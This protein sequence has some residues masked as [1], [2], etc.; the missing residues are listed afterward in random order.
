MPADTTEIVV[1]H[2]A[3]LQPS[4]I[5]HAPVTAF[6]EFLIVWLY[7]HLIKN[8]ICNVRGNISET[9]LSHSDISDLF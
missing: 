1:K 3:R 9:L 4:I 2:S 8:S 5:L 6:M 7:N